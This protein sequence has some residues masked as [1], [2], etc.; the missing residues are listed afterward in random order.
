[1]DAASVQEVISAL[2]LAEATCCLLREIMDDQRLT[3]LF[4][5]HRGRSYEKVITFPVMVRMLG[6]ALLQEGGTAHRAFGRA[7]EEGDLGAS[8]VAA[9]GKLARMPIN[10]SMAFLADST[11]P[12]LAL[13]PKQARR[14]SP[15]CLNGF[16]TIVLDG[17]AIKN[18]AKRLLP[19]RNAGGG[20]LGGRTL[21]A[22][23][24]ATGLVLAMHAVA[25]GDANDSRFVP[26]L[27]P[28]I[29]ERVKGLL[30]WLADRGFCDLNRL[31]DFT[32]DGNHFLVRYHKKNGFHPDADRKVL[33]G[34]D[35]QGRCF[36]E[37]WGWLG[38]ATHKKRR[39][40]RRITLFRPDE[41][42]VILVTDLIDPEEYP[43]TELLSHYLERWGIERV[44][45]QVT[46]TFG[47]QSLIGGTPEATIF[48]FSFCLLLYN[49]MQTIR[50]FVAKNQKRECES[51]SIENLF[52][53]TREELTTLSVLMRRGVIC[54]DDIPPR[55]NN[56]SR[57]LNDLLK[58]QW[59]D[60][61]IKAKNKNR[62]PHVPHSGK[63]THSSVFR[64]LHPELRRC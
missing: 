34:K 10:L 25:D 51:I 38:G 20:L 52:H 30:L 56:L 40:V 29:Q 12:L 50:G 63:R 36:L 13:F 45:Q 58:N 3:E 44:F 22:L 60:R 7:Q 32:N 4:N 26:D 42:A 11:E 8:M 6:D 59:S 18:V 21:V 62:R 33:K 17:K 54:I 49:A 1:M 2:P 28:V 64:L 43:A 19:L 9:Y 37:E 31:E 39:Y 24:Y 5:K 47:L 48:Q 16:E 35:E 55:Q 14:K 61:W 23:D 57:Q 15:P 41:E 53:D 27:M 46:E